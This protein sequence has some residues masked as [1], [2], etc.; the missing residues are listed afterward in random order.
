MFP[1]TGHI[2]I[3]QICQERDKLRCFYLELEPTRSHGSSEQVKNLF[4][5]RC[6]MGHMLAISLIVIY[7]ITNLLINLIL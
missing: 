6:G 5:Q 4:V 2:L 7:N 3:C 1:L